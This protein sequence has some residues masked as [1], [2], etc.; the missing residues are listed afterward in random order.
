MRADKKQ[1]NFVRRLVALSVDDGQVS[2]ERVAAILQTLSAKPPR[3]YKQVLKLYYRLLRTEVRRT[4]ALVQHAGDLKEGLLSE[5]E[6][7]FTN[8]YQRPIQADAKPNEDLIAG[9]RVRVGDDVYDDSV[10]GRLSL[11]GSRID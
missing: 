5:L 4:R 3:H 9:I 6:K 2:T 10:A 7:H 1:R 11:L 8:V